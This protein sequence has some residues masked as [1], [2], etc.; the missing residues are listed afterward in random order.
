[1]QHI[2][3]GESSAEGRPRYILTERGIDGE[4]EWYIATADAMRDHIAELEA[5]I[6]AT[7]HAIADVEANGELHKKWDSRR[8]RVPETR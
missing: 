5:E 8:R 2:E 1:M 4:S 6:E 7:R 3:E